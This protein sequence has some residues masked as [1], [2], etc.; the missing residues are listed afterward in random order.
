MIASD[1]AGILAYSLG[2][3][4]LSVT[5]AHG[6][7]HIDNVERIQLS[8]A[9]F[10]L[11]TQGPSG[12]AVAGHVWEAAALLWAGFAAAP[13]RSALGQWTAQADH[14]SSMGE[15]GQKM[16]DFYAP[17]ISASSLVAY[18]YQT[19]AGRTADA[20]TVQDLAG[21]IGAG[22]AFATEGDFFAYA[23]SLSLNTGHMADLVG[24]IQPLDAAWF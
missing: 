17:G 20:G 14:S 19:V 11:D 6:T 8:D 18:L 23:A 21:Q 12:N 2:G 7:Q 1:R 24:S 9:L 4:V 22:R 5:T 13:D 16:I 15:L 3:G 10:A